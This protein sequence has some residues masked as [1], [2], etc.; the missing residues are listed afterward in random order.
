MLSPDQIHQYHEQG[1]VIPDYRLSDDT[2]EEIKIAHKRL[3]AKSPQF[4][5]YCGALLIED[6]SFLNYARD[7]NILD[8]VSQ[9]IGPD[10][11]LWNSSFFAK[12]AKIGTR[13]PWHQD[14]EYWPIRPL[15]T[16]TVWIAI[17]ESNEDNGCLK[18]LTGSNRA[19]KLLPHQSLSGKGAALDK[20]IRPEF[21]EN[22]E[23]VSVPLKPGQMVIFDVFT[24]HGASPNLSNQR[25]A[26]FAIRYMPGTSIFDRNMKVGS[27]QDDVQTDLGQRALF[28]VRGEDKTGNN[29]F[30]IGHDGM[31]V[32][33]I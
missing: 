15:A 1:Y 16:A 3:I 18:I 7:Q 30:T 12:P 26:G 9:L 5:D 21:I 11:A 29:D 20:E 13:T 33:V 32:E 19:K 6:L 25:R 24:A 23:I 31:T 28:L 14:G 17:D 22:K 10:I 4:S 2:I 8:M 27:G